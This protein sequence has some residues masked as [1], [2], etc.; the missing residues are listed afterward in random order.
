MARSQEP[1][2]GLHDSLPVE[3]REVPAGEQGAAVA[4]L[5][6]AMRDNPLHV[7]VFGADRH[8]RERRLRRFLALLL[9]HV[10]QNGTVFGAYSGSRLIGVL[11]LI[12]P[13]RCRP[14]RI[15]RLRIGAR[16]A[17]GNHPLILLRI[18]RWLRIWERSEPG[19]PHFHLGP[20]AVAAPYRRRG[21]VSRLMMAGCAAMDAD[22]APAWLESDLS[23]NVD[24]YR[25]F[26]FSSVTTKSVLGVPNW[27]LSRV[28]LPAV[29]RLHLSGSD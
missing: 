13:G 22:G 23:V 2:K 12:G 21:I 1:G 25:Q 18:Y 8:A 29:G 26:G 7:R 24:F 27:F 14:G 11:G 9:G 5:A 4:L 6:A 15:D 16:I 20:L 17:A 10:R 28:E 19:F 3:V